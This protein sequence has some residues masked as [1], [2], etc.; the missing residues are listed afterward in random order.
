MI[1]ENAKVSDLPGIFCL[2]RDSGLPFDGS[3]QDLSHFFV[4]KE[5]REIIGC[6]GLEVHGKVGL[7]NSFAVKKEQQGQGLGKTLIRRMLDLAGKR[8]IKKIYL[9]TID[10]SEFFSKFGF[11][12][13]E[14]HEIDPA[15]PQTKDFFNCCSCSAI[16]MVKHLEVKKRNVQLEKLVR[17]F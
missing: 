13:V 12:R 8:S 3:A 17:Y 16:P 1:L 7:L 6:A 5:G 11:K 15:I 14:W 4:I 2:L 10:A 9:L